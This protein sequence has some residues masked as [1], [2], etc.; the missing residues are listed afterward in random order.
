ML[1]TL[2]PVFAIG[3]AHIETCSY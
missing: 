1:K 3:Y 2:V